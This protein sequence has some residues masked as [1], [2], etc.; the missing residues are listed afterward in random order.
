M[1]FT[2]FVPV[3]WKVN[4][5]VVGE[6]LVGVLLES[7]AEVSHIRSCPWMSMGAVEGDDWG[8]LGVMGTDC[9]L[10]AP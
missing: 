4:P 10:S 9:A 8:F 6:V 7:C 3:C 2:A 5:F 1:V